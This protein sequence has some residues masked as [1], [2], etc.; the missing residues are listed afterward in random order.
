MLHAQPVQTDTLKNAKVFSNTYISI[1]VFGKTRDGDIYTCGLK[2]VFV[3]GKAQPIQLVRIDLTTKK[4]TYKELAGIPS[5]P[6]ILWIHFF[7]S[8][9]NLYLSF[10]YKERVVIKLNLKDSIAYQNLGNVFKDNH[11][12][13]Y[14]AS[15]SHDKHIYFGGSSGDPYVSEYFPSTNK[16]IKYPSMDAANDFVLSVAGDDKYIYAQTGQ[17]NSIQLWAMRKSDST[18]KM[19]FKIPNNTRMNL[20]CGVDGKIYL[21][22]HCDTL[23]GSWKL[24]D[25]AAIHYQGSSAPVYYQEVSSNTKS[26]YDAVQKKLF[27]S[28]DGSRYDYTMINVTDVRNIIR[29]VFGFK[30][31]LSHLYMAGDYYGNYYDYNLKEDSSFLLGNTSF[32]VYSTLQESDSTIYF[33]NY[34]SGALLKW[35]RNLPWT[36]N[37][38]T[39]NHVVTASK[40][41][42][43]RLI[44]Y[45]K[46]QTPAGFH[47]LQFMKKDFKG[48]IVCAGNVIR[49]GN[50]CSIGVYDV[51]KD[52]LYGYDFLK[53]NSLSSSGLAAWKNL[54]IFSTGGNNAKLYFY[55]SL[56]NNMVDSLDLGFNDYGK[57]NIT[58]NIL[59]GIANDRIYKLDL[60]TKKI[61][62]N[63]SFQKNSILYS[64]TLS[65]GTILVKTQNQLPENFAKFIN[66]PYTGYYESGKN[67]YAINGT[68]IVVLKN[69]IQ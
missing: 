63:F 53:I 51:K 30:N 19:L 27:Y 21:S 39:G 69:I 5:S 25:G 7:D 10:I 11:S 55:N 49:I 18:K 34:P 15:L 23:S 12:T 52:S 37:K 66:L 26:F 24:E 13:I 45:L 4:I 2:N 14:S 38:F 17:R 32:N 47:H 28:F 67:V 56:L 61:I 50:T 57:I 36:L 6:S 68:E 43:P 42:N 3:N 1:D 31:D 60:S 35:N 65:N 22:F 44:G 62:Q 16:L 58:G 29:S 9:G 33:G 40:T 48:N 46:S 41:S 59:T 64:Q 54:M 20:M 8:T